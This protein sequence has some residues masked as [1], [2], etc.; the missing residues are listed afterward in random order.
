MGDCIE[1]RATFVAL[2]NHEPHSERAVR[3]DELQPG[4]RC[5]DHSVSDHSLGR[6]EPGET[7]I[8]V[9]VAPQHIGRDKLPKPAAL[10]DAERSGLS[11]FRESQATDGEIRNVAEGLVERARAS[12]GDKAGVFGVLRMPC[13][14]VRECRADGECAPG[15]CVYDTA[16]TLIPSHAEAFQRVHGTDDALRDARR[17]TLFSL[18]KSGFVSVEDFR[19]GLLRDLAPRA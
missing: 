2:N 5:Q 12:Q 15:Y 17:K 14:T 18:V 13:I 19:D 9:L 6:V 8:R 10:S 7:L 11:V 1:C 3:L 16:E 4:C